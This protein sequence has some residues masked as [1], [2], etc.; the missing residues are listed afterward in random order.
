MQNFREDIWSD[1]EYNYAAA[2]GFIPNIYAYLHDDDENRD[3]LLIAP[4]GGYCM[5]VPHEGEL[6][7]KVF[8]D[9]GMNVFVLTYTTD[10]TMSVPLKLQPLNDISRAVRFLRKKAEEYH[11]SGKKLII[12]GFS[13]GAHVCGSLATHF[14][15]VKDINPEYADISNRPDGVVL[16]Y[17]VITSG[18]YTHIY[19][20]QTLLGYEPDEKEMEYFSLEKQVSEDTPPCFLWQTLTDDLVPIENSYLFADALRKKAIPYAHYVFPYGRHGL[21][22]ADPEKLASFRGG[23]YTMEQVERAVEAVRRN[24]GVNVSEKRRQELI[25]QFSG[26]EMPPQEEEK[27]SQDLKDAAEWTKLAKIWIDRL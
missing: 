13:A 24:E 2:Y 23:E 26:E 11:I 1:G 3:C 5:C 18:E 10:I 9:M 14:A 12:M 15:D 4:G 22:V 6:A 16:S 27:D 19:S 25:I 17:P 7:A 21:S 8:F 20:F